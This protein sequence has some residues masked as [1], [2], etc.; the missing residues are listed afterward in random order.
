MQISLIKLFLSHFKSF[1]YD[2]KWLHC[3]FLYSV[4]TWER[5]KISQFSLKEKLH[6]NSILTDLRN[7]SC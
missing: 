6:N 5:K 7:S 1:I 3:C 2:D 4:G